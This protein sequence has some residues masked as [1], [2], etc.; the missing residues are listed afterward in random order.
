MWKCTLDPENSTPNIIN[1]E[2]HPPLIFWF[3][4]I[5]LL[6][7]IQHSHTFHIWKCALYPEIIAQH[8]HQQWAPSPISSCEISP[9][10]HL[11]KHPFPYLEV[12]SGPWK[13]CPMVSPAVS[14]TAEL[15]NAPHSPAWVI[16]TCAKNDKFL[17]ELGALTPYRPEKYILITSLSQTTF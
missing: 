6:F 1:S 7:F 10:F 17:L 16:A 3:F 13:E 14:T 8:H 9:I 4:P 5:L 11:Q 2:H 15:T 12:H